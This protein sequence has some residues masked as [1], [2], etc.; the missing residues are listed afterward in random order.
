MNEALLSKFKIP[1]EWADCKECNQ[2]FTASH[3]KDG[4]CSACKD[5][6]RRQAL[7]ESTF[8][9]DLTERLG[10]SR[11]LKYTFETYWET[12]DNSKALRAVREFSPYSGNLYLYGPCGTGKTHLATACIQRSAQGTKAFSDETGRYDSLNFILTQPATLFRSMRGLDGYQESEEIKRHGN[13]TCL[14]LDDLGSE[15]YTEF[16]IQILYDVINYRYMRERNGLI[17]TSNLPLRELAAK[18][19]DGRIPSRLAEMCTSVKVAGEDF[20]LKMKGTR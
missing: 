5:R 16:A 7:A 3:V 2:T 18:L 13:V 10:G 17:V 12:K 14:V 19:G 15:K 8:Q 1:T 20:R 6:P 4:L 11:A 9:Q